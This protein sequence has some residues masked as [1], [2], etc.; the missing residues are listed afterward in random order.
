MMDDFDLVV[1]GAG[2]A[3]E[4]AA[5]EARRLGAT[6]A[7]VD[8]ELFGGSCPFWAC[9]PSKA[10]LHAAGIHALGGDYPWSRASRFRDY[11]TSRE[12]R[13]TPD[14]SGHVK[15]LED[16]GAKVFRGIARVSDAGSVEVSGTSGALRSLTYRDLVVA[17]GT[18]STIP[19]LPGLSEITP[20]T[21]RQATS[22]RELPRSLVVVGGGP[23]GVELAQILARFG[24][25]VSLV[26]PEDHVNHRDLPRNSEV[27]AE[28]LRR[29]GVELHLNTRV[30]RIEARAGSEGAHRLHLENGTSIEG[31]EVLF[32][33]G[34]TSP[35]AGLGLENVGVKV[36]RGRVTPDESLRLAEHVFVA[37]DPA[38]PEMHTHLAHYQGEMAARIALGANVR[39]D[40]RAIPRAVYTDPEVA[41]VGLRPDQA[42]E[43][44]LDVLEKT[45]DMATSAKGYVT[46][47]YGH[48]TIYVD[49]AS[50]ELVGA[51][52][53]G[54]GAS[55]AI[56]MAVLA[57]KTRTPIEVLADTITAFPT[58]AR[59]MGGLFV[60]AAHE[61]TQADDKGS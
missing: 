27:L 42:A 61:L 50:R 33:I 10:L 22:L 5:F 58:T 44:G 3:G 7:I 36:E 45:A 15:R 59:V 48:A 43:A 49:R 21:N 31:H 6:V 37:G 35:L 14:D 4:A 20:W 2:A 28:A 18:H 34:R 16:A 30:D 12:D 52:L 1:I 38:G 53:A 39:P 9:M 25:R 46:D 17:V 13:E 51:F 55:E 19:D 32:S 41:G 47:A 29:D 11:I 57:I 23:T 60:E 24:V 40:Y 8:R 54:P 56:H 26:H